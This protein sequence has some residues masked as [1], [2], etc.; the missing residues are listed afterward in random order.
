FRIFEPNETTVLYNWCFVVARACFDDLQTRNFILWLVLDNLSEVIYILDTCV[1]LRTGFLEQGLLEKDLTKLR[2]SY[3]HTMQFKL[4]LL[5]ILPTDL[6]RFN[7]LMCFSRLFEFFDRTKTHTI[8]IHW[9]ALYVCVHC[10]VC[11][12]FGWVKCRAR[13]LSM[14]HHTWLNVTSL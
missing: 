11:V 10:S 12:H 1:R 14:G 8:I 13:I 9:N 7:R 5:S 2:E 4:Y 6:L 3:V